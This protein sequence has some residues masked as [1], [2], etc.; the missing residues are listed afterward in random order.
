[1][2][3]LRMFAIWLLIV[4][5][6][7]ARGAA[8]H[9]HPSAGGNVANVLIVI[10]DR[11]AVRDESFNV[12]IVASA[13]EAI[14]PGT[15]VLLWRFGG[16]QPLPQLVTDTTLAF[17]ARRSDLEG[18]VTTMFQKPGEA[19]ELHTCV[20]GQIKA[21]RDAFVA[22]LRTEL[23]IFDDSANGASPIV[24]A[25]GLALGPF[26]REAAE[27]RVSVLILTD[28]I[29]HS[30]GATF[31]PKDGRYPTPAEAVNRTKGIPGSW[32]GARIFVSGLGVT[33]SPDIVGV[34]SLIAIWREIIQLRGAVPV[35]LS[36]S[37]PVRLKEQPR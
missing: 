23:S 30:T 35:E 11:S 3:G 33:S 36:T 19:D 5:P 21:K 17:K 6:A 37:I 15:R 24:L 13:T 10:S 28:G 22:T 25:I 14:Q 2:I 27:G 18:L 29:E 12:G 16:V 34:S 1:M 20:L 8:D 31:Y 4:A 26:S 9:C 32:K 7:M